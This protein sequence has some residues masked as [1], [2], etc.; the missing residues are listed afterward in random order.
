MKKEITVE[1]NGL[2]SLAGVRT[3]DHRRYL[4]EDTPDGTIILVPLAGA[5]IPLAVREPVLR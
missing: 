3:H 5:R 4:A 2:T 1:A